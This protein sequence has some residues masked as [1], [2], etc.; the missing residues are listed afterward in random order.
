MTLPVGPIQIPQDT[1]TA[2]IRTMQSQVDEA[3]RQTLYSAVISSGGLTIRQGGAFVITNLTGSY[4]VLET[5][6]RTFGD[7]TSYQPVVINRPPTGE[8][9]FAVYPTASTATQP[10][11]WTFFDRSGNFVL[12]DDAASGKGLSKPWL[13]VAMYPILQSTGGAPYLQFPHTTAA[14]SEIWQ[15]TIPYVSHPYLQCVVATGS[16][17]GTGSSTFTLSTSGGG[18]STSWTHVGNFNDDT[19]TLDLRGMIGQSNVRL[20]L[21]FN[22]TT[23]TSTN[24]ICWG[25]RCFLRGT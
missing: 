17:S 7:G 8:P 3:T 25:P 16:A 13:S 19:V 22:S 12:T 2:Y 18:A 10:F 11:F 5:K 9:A 24:L 15:G 20:D 1:L 4:N 21:I 14:N 6:T 23:E